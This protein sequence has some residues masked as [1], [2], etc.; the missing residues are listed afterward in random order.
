FLPDERRELLRRPAGRLVADLLIE[1]SEGVSLDCAVDGSVQLVDDRARR[2]GW[3]RDPEPYRRRITGN[4]T[5][6]DR[7]QLREAGRTLR[8]ADAQ[9]ADGPLPG[10]RRDGREALEH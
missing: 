8:T 4:A 5:L 2:A 3:R 1:C 7:R 10:V 6:R 9:R